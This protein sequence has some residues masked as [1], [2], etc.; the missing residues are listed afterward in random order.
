MSYRLGL[1]IGSTSIGWCMIRLNKE[2]P[3]Q[4]IAIIKMGVRIFPDGRNPKDGSSLAV[5]RRAAR[6]MRRRRDRLLKRKNRLMSALINLGFFPV[7][8]ESR[9][10]LTNLDPYVLRRK[11]LDAALTP[12][13]FARALFHINQRRGFKSNRKTDKG[14]SDTGALKGAIKLVREKLIADG[15]RTIGEWLAK[16]HEMKESVRARLRG[17]GS[18]AV[19]DFYIDRAMIEAEFDALWKKQAE[20]QPQIFSEEKRAELKDILLFQRPLRPVKP[21]RCTL[22]AHEERAPLALPST[23]QFRIFQEVNNLRLLKENLAEQ[24]LTL[25]QRDLIVDLLNKSK[26]V[27][28]TAI[29]K[30][31]KLGG[32]AKFNLEDAKR[33][34]LKGNATSVLLAKKDFLGDA[35]TQLSLQ[36][37]DDLVQRLITEQS[38]SKIISELEKE[39]S[40]DEERAE[41]I[42]NAALPDGYGSLCRKALDKVLPELKK[43]VVTFDKAVIAAG[44]EHHSAISHSQQTGEVL[45]ALP[46][47]G[48]ALQRHVSFARENPKNDEERYGKIANPTVHIG[49]NELR[50]VV[51]RLLERY[52]HPTEVIVE[53]A[54][55]LKQSKKVRDEINKDQAERQ[56]QNDQFRAQIKD[57]LGSEPKPQD[58]QKMRLWME[59]NKSDAANRRCPYT[60]EQISIEMLY[61]DAVEIEHILPFAITLDDSLNNKTV[62]LRRA[63]RDK[64]NKTPYEAFGHSPD[65]YDFQTILERA[66][67]MPKEK[68]KRFAEDGY[69][70]WLKEDDGFLARALTDTAYLSRIAKEYLS[71]IC[72][73]N[74]VRAIPGRM[75]AMLR[76][77]FGLN[78]LLSGNAE[79]NRDDH[80]HHAIDAAVIAITDQGML[81]RFA[82][83]SADAREAQL[84]RLIKSMPM[85]WP[86]YREQVARSVENVIISFKPDHGYQGALHNDTTYGLRAEGKVIHRVPLDK[87]SSD[88]EIEKAE[89]ADSA[90][91]AWLLNETQNLSGKEFKEKLMQVTKEFRHRRVRILEKLA[92]IPLSSVKAGTRHGV[93]EEGQPANYKGYLGNSNYCIE[94]VKMESGKWTGEVISTFQAHQI[95]K[96]LGEE[97]GFTKLRNPTKSQSG[98]ELVMRLMIGD[99]VKM[100]VVGITQLM[101]VCAIPQSGQMAFSAH[102]EANVD[103]RNR[104]KE[105]S[106]SYVTKYPGSL[107][108][109]KAR[110]I[111]VSPIGEF[112]DLGFNG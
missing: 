18:K 20:L 105:N 84:N 26:E 77:K 32:T 15:S 97:E 53:V 3:P 61:S 65:G 67:L 108:A 37:Q 68:A 79:K 93:N 87:F 9:N 2:I 29:K 96:T 49:L 109:T 1:D 64:G 69:Q 38:E 73:H 34:K 25:E 60:G 63:N 100:E 70:R 59:L 45:S 16:R 33:D 78:A 55:D 89:F 23:Q 107:Q 81:G 24:S 6:A 99:M 13:E 56:K 66:K 111:A 28:F 4:P 92:V 46:Y 62:S 98:K 75:T 90:L 86:S 76:G 10:A 31:L 14:A 91:Q 30:A 41:R 5:T 80:R 112:R 85:P 74:N 44:F 47:Y 36:Q 83:A 42:A 110:R 11:G 103:A 12:P 95:V 27:T 51:N 54:R 102:T 58:I 82:K 43:A 71:L 7:D 19:Y 94:I 39:F 21:G 101:R 40:I 22:L 50:K 72:P 104:D 88:K 106:F 35:W 52:G 17:S 57:L 48:E 8:A